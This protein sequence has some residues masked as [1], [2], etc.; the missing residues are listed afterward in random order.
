MSRGDQSDVRQIRMRAAIR[1]L[2]EVLVE[3]C[4]HEV[5]VEV[6]TPARNWQGP[7]FH[8]GVMKIC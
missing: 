1:R 4:A 3:H 6:Q 5:S 2:V 8:C 7:I